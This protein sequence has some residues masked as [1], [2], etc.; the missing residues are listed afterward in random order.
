MVHI[1]GKM[2]HNCH[3]FDKL[4][5]GYE[6]SKEIASPE[7]KIPRCAWNDTSSLEIVSKITSAEDSVV[8]PR[9]G[10]KNSHCALTCLLSCV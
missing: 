10:F 3:P 1:A 5:V 6:R 2:S 9:R 4:R 8:M 7:Q